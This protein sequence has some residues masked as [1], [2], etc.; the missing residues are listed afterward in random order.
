M[1]RLDLTVK[2][3]DSGHYQSQLLFLAHDYTTNFTKV[4]SY[5]ELH[6]VINP[7]PVNFRSLKYDT[8]LIIWSTWLVY[9]NGFIHNKNSVQVKS[10]L[11]VKNSI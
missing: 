10:S 6:N 8:A 3:K 1:Y 2:F 4:D 5:T 7:F 11:E 9:D